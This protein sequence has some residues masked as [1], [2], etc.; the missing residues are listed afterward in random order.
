MTQQFRF[1]I[2]LARQ[3]FLFGV[4]SMQVTVVTA[5]PIVP[6]TGQHVPQVG[7]DF[8]DPEWK[9]NP[10]GPKSSEEMDGHQRMPL[11][12]TVNNRWYEGIK[13]GYPDIVRR[14]ATPE[15]GPEGSQGALLI[16]SLNSGIP[17]TLTHR[18]QQEDLVADCNYRLRGAIPVSQS[19]SVVARVYLPPFEKWENRTGVSFGFRASVDSMIWK[20]GGRTR[21]DYWPGMMIEFASST[22]KR[23]KEDA[24]YFRIR[25]NNRGIDLKGPKIE[26]TGWWTLGMSFTPDG[27][28]HYY[29]RPGLENLTVEDHL[30]S[31]VPYGYKCERFKTFFFNVCNMDDGKTWSTPWVVDN[32]ELYYIPLQS[33]AR[34]DGATKR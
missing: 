9:F 27:Q 21:E 14:V 30:M 8:E 31:Q 25:A 17:G 29:A 13:R 7:D 32:C 10:A 1:H 5:E 20:D 15:G 3:L 33:H 26:K 2:Q 4:L 11:G 12:R 19:P 18:M 23:F 6:G 28:V 34:R 16:Q 22:D 24:A